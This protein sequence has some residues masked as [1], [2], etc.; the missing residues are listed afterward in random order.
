MP[1][2]GATRFL[3]SRAGCV[4]KSLGD[5]AE[6]QTSRFQLINLPVGSAALEFHSQ[7]YKEEWVCILAGAS[8]ARVGSDVF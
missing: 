3:N 6:L 1:G 5:R 4:T 2:K 7:L 8:L